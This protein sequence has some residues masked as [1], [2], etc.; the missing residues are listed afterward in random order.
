MQVLYSSLHNLDM[1][2]DMPIRKS[3]PSDFSSYMEAYIK[4][5][6]KDNDTSREYT[7]VDR[8]R[9]VVNCISSIFSDILMQG[10]VIANSEDADEY[11][12]S[13]AL[14]LLDTEKAV[15]EQIGSM[16]QVQ[17]GSIVQALVADE[18]GYKFIIAKI[19]HSEW[20]HGETLIK[21]LGFPGE[22]KRV[23]KSVVMCLEVVDGTVIFTSIKVHLNHKA[24][25]WTA[26]FLEIQEAKTDTVNT[27]A[28]FAGV[29][30]VLKPLIK[31]SPQ[32][33]Y[34]IRNS[35]VTQLQKDQTINYTDMVGTI[36]DG[37][38]PA[39]NNVAAATL[40]AQLIALK[41]EGHFDTQF[42]T[43]PKAM[44][45]KKRTTLDVTQCIQ[46][47][48][49]EGLPDWEENFRIKRKANGQNYLMIRCSDEKTLKAFKEDEE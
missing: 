25:Y 49:T 4:F 35:V 7:L 21:N 43:D 34:N 41:N 26:K 11:S 16:T 23:W 32:D 47:V 1:N 29:E 9:T 3:I 8:N 6:T 27:K 13:I 14:K 28:V 2:Q 20:Y 33:Y 24:E 12:D 46:V 17:K 42:H 31:K 22:N 40:K 36:M 10:G 30:R 38:S 37:Y 18:E 45:R 48:V 44:K 19:E 5:A 39:G 15:Q